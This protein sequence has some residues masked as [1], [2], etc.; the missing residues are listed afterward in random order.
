MRTLVLT[1]LIYLT[2]P[3]L[4]FS[5]MY[6]VMPT[7][8]GIQ[9]ANEQYP[10]LYENSM[11]P[12][13]NESV[14]DE[15]HIMCE[16]SKLREHRAR[17]FDIFCKEMIKITKVDS[18]IG[19]EEVMLEAMF[20]MDKEEF[21][22]GCT[23]KIILYAIQGF[24]REMTGEERNARPGSGKPAFYAKKVR[25]IVVDAYVGMWEMYKEELVRAK[26]TLQDRFKDE[27]GLTVKQVSTRHRKAVARRR[28]TAEA[29]ERNIC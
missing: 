1:P 17:I 13:C 15:H 23:P 3:H 16:C 11:C 14:G 5:L 8:R 12:L 6:R 7:P 19:S 24:I 26:K 9:V 4:M 29:A 10:K 22:Y 2:Q 18:I 20:P 28:E 27:Y 25:K 21:R